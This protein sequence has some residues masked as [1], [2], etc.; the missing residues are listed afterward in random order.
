MK[1]EPEGQ[2]TIIVDYGEA[3]CKVVNGVSMETVE[4]LLCC[5]NCLEM[6]LN[7]F[8]CGWFHSCTHPNKCPN[9]TMRESV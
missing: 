4:K 3:E 1:L 8:Y 5:G 9:W 7:S 2:L 6:D